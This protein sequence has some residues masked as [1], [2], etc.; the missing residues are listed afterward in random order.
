MDRRIHP[1]AAEAVAGTRHPEARV[2]VVG[3]LL[4]PEV[5]AG[6][7]R[8]QEA[9]EPAELHHPE[10]AAVGPAGNRRDSRRLEEAV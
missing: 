3:V 4:H 9:E 10:V 1:V 2:E 8:Q 6:P 5:V 7:L